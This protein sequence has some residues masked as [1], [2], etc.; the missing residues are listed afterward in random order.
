M[1]VVGAAEFVE[2]LNFPAHPFALGGV[3]GAYHDEVARG[4]EPFL[5]LRRKS[6]R[7]YVGG[8]EK[9]RLDGCTFPSVL[10]AQCGGHT[11]ML[12][13]AL[14]ALAPLGVA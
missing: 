3:G 5:Q 2:E 13:F 4:F 1:N 8:S 12:Q 14:H 9:H 6:A 7:L 10:A 11:V